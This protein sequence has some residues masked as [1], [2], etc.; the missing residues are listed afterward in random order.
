VFA[1]APVPGQM[2]STVYTQ[3]AIP[4]SKDLDRLNLAMSWR[5][6]LPIDG[7]ADG[8]ATVQIIEDR[9][10]VQTRSNVLVALRASSGEEDWRMALPKRYVP[11]FPVAVNQTLVCVANGPRIYF[12][13]RTNGKTKYFAD[14]PSTVGAGLAVDLHQ[15]FVVLANSRMISIG[16]Q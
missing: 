11:A 4:S 16:L 10:Y 2:N 14:L 3:P 5:A 15:C 8:I 7:R 9:V 1:A 13:D 12:L 6:N